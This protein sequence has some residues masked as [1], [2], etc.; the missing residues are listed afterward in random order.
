MQ[1]NIHTKDCNHRISH[2]AKLTLVVVDGERKE[3]YVFCRL[4]DD[5][6]EV[7]EKKKEMFL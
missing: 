5:D 7:E 1:R 6:I 3:Y 2:F 4:Y